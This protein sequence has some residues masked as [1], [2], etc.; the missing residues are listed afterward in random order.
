MAGAR[1]QLY[2]FFVAMAVLFTILFLDSLFYYLPKVVLASIII[3]AAVGKL[4]SSRWFLPSHSHSRSLRGMCAG[5]AEYEDLVFLWKIRDLGA[6]TLLLATFF[7]TGTFLSPD[8]ARP[9]HA[10]WPDGRVRCA[11]GG[12]I[13]GAGC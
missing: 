10:S 2:N 6:I 4:P 11:G 1:T 13:S 3:V 12:V 5:L 7:I 8:L 9:S